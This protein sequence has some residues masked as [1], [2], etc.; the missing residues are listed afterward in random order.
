MTL[1]GHTRNLEVSRQSVGG[2][3][4]EQGTGLTIGLAIDTGGDGGD[5]VEADLRELSSHDAQLLLAAAII[6]EFLFE[7]F[8]ETL[9]VEEVERVHVGHQHNLEKASN[10]R[11]RKR[12]AGSGGGTHGVDEHAGFWGGET[13][14]VAGEI[15]ANFVGHPS[16]QAN[17]RHHQ[18]MT[19]AFERNEKGRHQITDEEP[20]RGHS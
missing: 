17:A 20:I 2:K 9:A 7:A 10:E 15:Q 3:G 19:R 16:L 13:C 4:E 8:W 1:S 18:I 12:E 11:H 14:V 5:E 6:L